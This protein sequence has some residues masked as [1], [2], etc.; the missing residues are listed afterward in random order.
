MNRCD[1]G[2][3]STVWME[4]EFFFMPLCPEKRASSGIFLAL[5]KEEK[6]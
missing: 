2:T 1:S 4:E 6:P 5:S 3:D